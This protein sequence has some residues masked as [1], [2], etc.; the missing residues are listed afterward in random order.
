LSVKL[1][2]LD[3][4]DAEESQQ[5][6]SFERSIFQFLSIMNNGRLPDTKVDIIRNRLVSHTIAYAAVIQLYNRLDTPDSNKKRLEAA[7]AAAQA[8]ESMPGIFK[9]IYIDPIMGV[10]LQLCAYWPINVQLSH[11]R[12]YGWL[13]ARSLFNP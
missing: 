5:F 10:R 13:F 2:I 4:A 12:L 9:W 3:A 1:T 6:Q 7:I 8:A 11:F